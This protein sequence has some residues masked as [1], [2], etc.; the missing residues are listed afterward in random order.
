MT[1][2][3]NRNQD[4]RIKEQFNPCFEHTGSNWCMIRQLQK[5]VLDSPENDSGKIPAVH[6]VVEG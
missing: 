1:S 4:E 3:P 6:E 2:H 5:I